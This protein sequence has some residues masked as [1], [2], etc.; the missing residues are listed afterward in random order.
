MSTGKKRS[1]RQPG[2]EANEF[3]I[4]GSETPV[5]ALASPEAQAAAPGSPR[6]SSHVVE[7]RC[8]PR[9]GN[10]PATAV[11]G[12]AERVGEEG[13]AGSAMY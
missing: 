10:P 13:G 6:I 11:S 2:K 8:Q 5:K 4:S 7:W 1:D 12:G 9:F 3:H